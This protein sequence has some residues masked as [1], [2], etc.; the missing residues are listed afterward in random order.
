MHPKNAIYNIVECTIKCTIFKF[1]F[2]VHLE[3]KKYLFIYD[4]FVKYLFFIY[5]I[6]ILL[7]S[8]GVFMSNPLYSFESDGLI[9]NV[10]F[11]NYNIVNEWHKEVQPLI[12]D[13]EPVRPDANWDW[14]KWYALGNM[15]KAIGQKAKGY[16][17]SVNGIPV[18]LC[19]CAFNYN[20]TKDENKIPNFL[21]LM[22][23]NPVL[24]D[25]LDITEEQTGIRPRV[26]VGDIIFYVLI[27]EAKGNSKSNSFWLHASN[28]GEFPENLLEY[29]MKKQFLH[30]ALNRNTTLRKDDGRYFYKSEKNI[31]QIQT[32][33]AVYEEVV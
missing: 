4:F 21:W 28:D 27:E 14:R 24:D 1:C 22:S 6:I 29:Y 20:C 16:S 7:V 3:V 9:V 10:E 12:N 30:C 25:I 18:G 11:L 13:E 19:Y 26:P 5:A 17:I 31:M 8:K 2:L 33:N 15:Y 23:R 32:V